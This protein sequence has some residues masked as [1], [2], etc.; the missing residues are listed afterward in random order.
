VA[1]TGGLEDMTGGD[2]AGPWLDGLEAGAVG[3]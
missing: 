2:D 3:A 1:G